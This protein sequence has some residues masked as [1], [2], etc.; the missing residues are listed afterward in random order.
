MKRL[1]K[2]AKRLP[3]KNHRWGYAAGA[4]GSVCFLVTS[5]DWDDRK[6]TKVQR[7]KA[8]I[9]Y[10]FES[11][12]LDEEYDEEDIA[13]AYEHF[14]GNAV[15]G[16]QIDLFYSKELVWIVKTKIGIF[17]VSRFGEIEEIKKLPLDWEC[18]IHLKR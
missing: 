16:A 18:D 13:Q 5:C 15:D 6:Y 2:T 1:I 11:V 10:L 4:F 12:L 17:S 8:G 9:S 3:S 14:E 7:V